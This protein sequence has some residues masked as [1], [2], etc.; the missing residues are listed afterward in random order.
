MENKTNNL[1]KILTNNNWSKVLCSQGTDKNE[2]HCFVDIFYEKEFVNYRDKD[3]TLLEIGIAS[4]YSL[5]LWN[6]YFTAGSTI[7]GIDTRSR[8]ITKLVYEKQNI[9]VMIENAY[10]KDVAQKL[11]DFDIIIDDGPH[12]LNSML[13]CI[14]LYLSKLKRGG[15]LI[16]EDVQSIDWIDHLK[17]VFNKK[18]SENDE[19]EIIDLRKVKNRYDDLLFVIRR[20]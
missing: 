12:T 19:C 18:K 2:T 1:K 11:P 6:E 13:E 16:I 9:K 15:M 4:G 17:L 5:L 20:K 7:Y 8:D 14:N 3:I 10:S